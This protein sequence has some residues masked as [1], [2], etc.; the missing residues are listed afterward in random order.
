MSPKVYLETRIL[1]EILIYFNLI[2]IIEK[3]Y[4]KP[5][6]TRGLVEHVKSRDSLLG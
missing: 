1:N 6:A 4:I 2:G 3:K 5:F